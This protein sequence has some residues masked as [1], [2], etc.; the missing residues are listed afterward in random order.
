[1]YKRQVK[2]TP[3][4][5][6]AQ[7]RWAECMGQAGHQVKVIDDPTKQLSKRLDEVLFGSADSPEPDL[8]GVTSVPGNATTTTT[9]APTG[10]GTSAVSYTHLTLP[11]SDLV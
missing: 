11:T 6:T 3:E 1:M 7:Q 5:Q 9:T 2:I 10:P 4:L 8:G